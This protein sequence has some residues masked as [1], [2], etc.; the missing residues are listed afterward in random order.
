MNMID[1]TIFSNIVV[2]V[3]E[4]IVVFILIIGLLSYNL[5]KGCEVSNIMVS[6]FG[7]FRSSSFWFDKY[8]GL[9]SEELEDRISISGKG[10]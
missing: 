5:Y 9:N 6:R 1:Y 8:L 3:N 7:V 2:G 10:S 4:F